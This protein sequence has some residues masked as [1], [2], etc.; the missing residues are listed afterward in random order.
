MN[1]DT[2]LNVI[3]LINMNNKQIIDLLLSKA[4][5]MLILG[6]IGKRS[7]SKKQPVAVA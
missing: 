5:F 7:I 6:I 3:P 4:K 2:S 1:L